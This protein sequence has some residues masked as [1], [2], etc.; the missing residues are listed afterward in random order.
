MNF[1]SDLLGN[2]QNNIPI[3]ENF[4]CFYIQKIRHNFYTP[5]CRRWILGHHRLWLLPLWGKP[6]APSFQSHCLSGHHLHLPPPLPSLHMPGWGPQTLK[7]S[8]PNLS[9]SVDLK[10]LP[11]R[12]PSECQDLLK[13]PLGSQRGTKRKRRRVLAEKQIVIFCNFWDLTE[14]YEFF[15]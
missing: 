11:D 10:K 14:C 7:S 4:C 8:S 13:R 2:Y 6:K 5:W 9:L 3:I 1:Y 15:H 12:V